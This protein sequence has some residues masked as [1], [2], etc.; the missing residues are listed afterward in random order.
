M[1]CY[2]IPSTMP[3]RGVRLMTMLVWKFLFSFLDSVSHKSPNALNTNIL[4]PIFWSPPLSNHNLI[5]SGNTDSFLSLSLSLSLCAKLLLSSSE[6]SWNRKP[7]SVHWI[8]SVKTGKVLKTSSLDGIQMVENVSTH[9]ITKFHPY[10]LYGSA[11]LNIFVRVCTTVLI[12]RFC[13]LDGSRLIR[14]EHGTCCSVGQ[15]LFICATGVG[16]CSLYI[17]H[18]TASIVL[19]F[20]NF[21][22]RLFFLKKSKMLSELISVRSL[23]YLNWS[24]LWGKIFY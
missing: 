2:F 1:W 6:F 8:K 4:F 11:V 13:V 16:C 12:S 7:V 14:D 22:K 3:H 9:D 24:I 23:L 18:K 17:W 15:T 10:K 19:K 5:A 20:Q 21:F